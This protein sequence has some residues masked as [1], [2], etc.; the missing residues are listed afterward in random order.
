[1]GSLGAGS[2]RARL[3]PSFGQNGVVAVEPPLPSPWQSQGVQ[4]LAAARDGSSYALFRRLRCGGGPCVYS[5][6]VV[7]YGPEGALDSTFGGGGSYELPQE[8]ASA[9]T[10][11]VDRQGRPLLAETSEGSIV[12]RRLTSFGAPD[13][14]FA[15]GGAVTL[16]CDCQLW[17][18]RIVPGPRGGVTV[19]APLKE[20]PHPAPEVELFR[21]AEDGALDARFGPGGSVEVPLPGY[22]PRPFLAEGARGALYLGGTSCC[23]HTARSYLVRVSI[24]GGYDGRFAAATRR[25]LRVLEGPHGSFATVHA[26]VARPD[27]GIDLLGRANRE[28]GFVLRLDSNGHRN[29]KL[30]RKGLLVLPSRVSSATLGSEGSILAVTEGDKGGWGTMTRI[31]AGGRLDPSLTRARIPGSQGDLGFSIASQAGRKALV[32]DLGEHICRGLCQGAPELVRFLEG[33]P[34]KRR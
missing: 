6:V 10:L 21:L 14:S 13:P 34:P 33:P 20:H 17:D 28:S 15:S 29:R 26:V 30:G 4:E 25:S 9:E 7:R 12:V 1:M 3:D 5:D 16:G 27:G 31:L 18:T 8:G 19:V 23:G 32:M 22:D 11:S 2:A 24:R